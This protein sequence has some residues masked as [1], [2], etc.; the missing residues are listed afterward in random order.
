MKGEH[1]IALENTRT[2][3]LHVEAYVM[4]KSLNA[5]VILKLTRDSLICQDGPYVRRRD[6]C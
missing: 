2:Y 4:F 3:S 6:L 5:M 1:S